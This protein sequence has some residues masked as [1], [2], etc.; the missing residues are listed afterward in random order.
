[1]RAAEEGN[2]NNYVKDMENILQ[3]EENEQTI[4]I[5]L[6]RD[7]SKE[8]IDSGM[9]AARHLK[10]ISFISALKEIGKNP[11]KVKYTQ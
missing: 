5:M 8:I 4:L 2:G 11:F 3:T 10:F 7:Q 9:E 1:M 6:E